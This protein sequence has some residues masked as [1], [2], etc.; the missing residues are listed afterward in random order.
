M[1]AAESFSLRARLQEQWK[2]GLQIVTNLEDVIE[3]HFQSLPSLSNDEG[4]EAEDLKT[5]LDVQAGLQAL[6]ARVC[7]SI[8]MCARKEILPG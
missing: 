3:Q 6:R 1:Q 7:S 8:D 4:E 2:Q 5:P